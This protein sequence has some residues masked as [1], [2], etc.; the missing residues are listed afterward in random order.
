MPTYKC[1]NCSHEYSYKPRECEVCGGNRILIIDKGDQL[2][3]IDKDLFSSYNFRT[4]IQNYCR[5]LDWD[6]A[7]IN[8]SRV[9]LRFNMDFGT[10]TV[11]I[12]KYEN[13]LE[14]SCPSGL[15]F[16]SIEE[17]PHVLSTVLL[18]RNAQSKFGFWCI[19]EISE[20]LV[21]SVMYNAEITLIDV[22]YFN[23]IVSYLVI[24]CEEFEKLIEEMLH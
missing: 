8:N 11:F 17:V 1:N 23:R 24:E 16:N 7:D 14:F 9:I 18:Q 13:T 10:Q 21:F 5:Q 2:M 15:K 6:I 19:E 4:T 20:K 12:I 3:A 22:N